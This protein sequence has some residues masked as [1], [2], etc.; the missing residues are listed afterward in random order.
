MNAA[1]IKKRER[2]L[3]LKD[4]IN[5]RLSYDPKTGILTNKISGMGVTEGTRAGSLD[6]STGY[7]RIGINYR[8]YKEHI[9]IWLI[10]FGVLPLDE[11][12]HKNHTR[13]DNRLCNLRNA[14]HHQNSLNASLAS[15]NTSGTTGVY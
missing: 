11:I 8:T 10:V 9:V 14:T 3:E 13:D 4:H 7:R 1:Q 5:N 15:N 6:K 12:D 2:L